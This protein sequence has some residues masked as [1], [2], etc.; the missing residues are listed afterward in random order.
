[1]FQ[2]VECDP[3]LINNRDVLKG[4]IGGD[5]GFYPVQRVVSF[6]VAFTAVKWFFDNGGRAPELIWDEE[7]RGNEILKPPGLAELV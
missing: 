5:I 1:V 2:L 7:T 3:A 4:T 6:E